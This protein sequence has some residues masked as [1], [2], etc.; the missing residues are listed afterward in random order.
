MLTVALAGRPNV[1]KSILFNRLS[2]KRLAI[3]EE[4]SGVTRDRL[5][6]TVT[7]DDVSFRLIDTGGLVTDPDALEK[8]ITTQTEAA[9]K[10]ADLILF[11]VSAQDGRTPMDDVVASRLR[12]TGK[13]VWLVI[14]KADNEK[15]KNAWADFC[16]YEFSPS[17]T[18]SA[19]HAIGTDDLLD[20]LLK[21]ASHFSETGETP[22][23]EAP[24]K[25]KDVAFSIAFVGKPNAGKSSLLNALAGYERAIVSDIPG[26]TRDNVDTVIDWQYK[27][28]SG[29][30]KSKKILLVDTAGIRRKRSIDTKLEVFSVSRSEAAIKRANVCVLLIDATAG[31]SVTDKKI[32]ATIAA[33]GRPCVIG[34]NKWDLMK[35]KTDRAAYLGWLRNEL[36]FLAYAPMILISAKEKQNIPA[37]MSETMKI[38][39]A[40]SKKISTGLL[41]RAIREAMEK[42]SPAALQGKRLKFYYATQTDREPPTF[43]LFVNDPG[44]VMGSYETYLK[45]ALRAS[46]K[47]EGAPLSLEWKARESQYHD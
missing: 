32:A 1:G 26:T 15:F 13:E 12:R 34:V 44:L 42:Q 47:L 46:L 14:N 33:A 35:G 2:G 19:M 10:E 39:A 17:V 40:V 38:Y 27:N 3:V 28:R 30:T 29:E 8:Q 41:N 36:P 25:P 24:E 21:K 7:H 20:R 37:L 45:K 23:E 5:Y 43:L 6:A 18:I 9:V 31:I 16:S 4:T 22:E 11:V